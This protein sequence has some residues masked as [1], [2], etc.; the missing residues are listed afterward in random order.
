MD[1]FEFK[2]KCFCLIIFLTAFALITKA[3]IDPHSPPAKTVVA[4]SYDY[5]IAGGEDFK[6]SVYIEE[7]QYFFYT[8]SFD[9]KFTTS[10][11]TMLLK[12]LGKPA[13]QEDNIMEWETID[14]QVIRSLY[15]SL[16]H[17]VVK[18]KSRNLTPKMLETLQNLVETV[19][20]IV[21][22]KLIVKSPEISIANIQF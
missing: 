22:A 2:I 6:A 16:E 4:A 9:K 17:G 19:N 10:V 13:Y 8:S 15:I 14:G 21:G 1:T 20:K 18:I 3:Q 11:S 7:N 12:R 5:A